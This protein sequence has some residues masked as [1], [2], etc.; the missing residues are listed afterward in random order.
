VREVWFEKAGSFSWRCVNPKG[1]VAQIVTAF[2]LFG[3]GLASWKVEATR[4]TFGL[5]LDG[6]AFVAGIA[7][8]AIIAVHTRN[9]DWYP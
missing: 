3:F 5:V 4:P 6:A 7:G 8:L 2:L 9:R 1:R